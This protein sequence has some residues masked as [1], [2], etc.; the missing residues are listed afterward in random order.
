MWFPATRMILFIESQTIDRR[1]ERFV[2]W[3]ELRQ[4]VPAAPA[5]CNR[6][7]SFALLIQADLKLPV[8]QNEGWFLY[9]D[10]I[11]GHVQKT[12]QVVA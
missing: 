12:A 11:G 3:I 5:S 6:G 7:N 9:I 4:T 8:T 10:L 1:G 2:A